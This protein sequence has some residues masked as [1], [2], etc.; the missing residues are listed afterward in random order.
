MIVLGLKLVGLD[1][2]RHSEAK[3]WSWLD[4]MLSGAQ[5]SRFP[6]LVVEENKVASYVCFLFQQPKIP[7]SPRLGL[8]RFTG[9]SLTRNRPR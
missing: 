3:K 6:H 7:S 5:E 2:I 8:F 9:K 4:L 1:L